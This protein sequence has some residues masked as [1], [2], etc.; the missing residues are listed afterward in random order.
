[1][2]STNEWN[3][4]NAAIVRR[5]K[6][7]DRRRILGIIRSFSP[8]DAGHAKRDLEGE[9]YVAELDGEIIGVTGI[10]NDDLSEK[11]CW[12]GWTYVEE[13]HRC[14]GLG[15]RLL[16][17]I[18]RL[19]SQRGKA[20]F[21]TASSHPAYLPAIQFYK[22]QG[23]AIAGALPGFYGP[24]R[25]LITLHRG[26]ADA[27]AVQL[28]EQRACLDGLADIFREFGVLVTGMSPDDCLQS[29]RGRLEDARRF[30][31][32]KIA[33]VSGEARETDEVSK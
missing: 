22:A 14:Q 10:Q 19:A 2:A 7:G 29:L 25:D 11:A 4:D 28:Q 1:M 21:I 3:E 30:R 12:L 27:L 16:H 5:A 15:T 23:Y 8:V 32:V 9:I 17:H 13:K 24:G 31:A 18:E 6:P 20:L 26:C 33:P